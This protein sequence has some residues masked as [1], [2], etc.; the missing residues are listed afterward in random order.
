GG[1]RAAGGVPA[2]GGGGGG[3]R[4]IV[5]AP[6]ARAGRGARATTALWAPLRP[7]TEA[8]MPLS[9]GGQPLDEASLGPYRPVLGRLIPDWRDGTQPDQSSMVVLGEAVLRLLAAT[10]RGS[11]SVLILEDLHDADTET[12]AVVEYLI[13]NLEQLPVMLLATV[14]A[15][16][17]DALGLA[18][19]AARRRTGTVLRLPPLSRTEVIRMITSCLDADPTQVPA[20]L[21]QRLWK[22]SA[23]NPFLV[24]ELL[25]GIIGDGSLVRDGAGGWRMIGDIRLNLPSALVQGVIHRIDRLGSQGQMLMSAAAVLG[26]RF[27]LS[28]LQQMTGIDD[29]SLLSHLHAGVAA[30]LVIPDE[31]APDWYAF[32]HPLTAEAL[33]TQLTPTNRAGLSERAADAV[34]ALHPGLEGEWCPLV[35]SLRSDAGDAARAGRLFTEAGRRALEDGAI[36][37]AVALLDRAERLLATGPDTAARAEALEALLPAL[38]ETGD[39]E[40]AL[41]L[42]DSLRQLVG[43]GLGATRLAALHTRLAQV[44][45]MAG[46][47]A[48]GN[49]QIARARALLGPEPDEVHTAQ[50]DVV[51]AYLTLD[52]PGPDRTQRAE[53]LVSSAIDAAERHQLPLVACQAWELLGVL[54]RERDMGEA[55]ACLQQ[56]LETAERHN[57]PLQRMYA[58][59]RL[60][61][62]HW[63]ASGDTTTLATAREE[64]QRLGAVTVVYTIDGILVLHSVLLGR[65]AEARELS[66]ECLTMAVRLRLAPVARYVLMA[67]AVL[68]AHQGDRT[69]MDDALAEFRRTDGTGSQ[70]EPLVYGLAGAFCALLEE[71]RPRA[72]RELDKVRALEAENPTTFHLDGRRGIGLLLDVLAGTADRGRH[73]EIATSSAGRM[74]WN[75]H[76][77]LLADAVLLGQEGHPEAAA[78]AAHEAQEIAAAHPTALHLGHRLVAE[79]AH[80]AHWGAP[81]SWLRQAEHHFEQTSIPAVAG[82]CRSLLRQI[83]A[84][85]RQHRAGSN[86]IPAQLRT[87]GVTVREYEVF[88]LL[89]DRLSNKAIATRLYIS[90]RTVEKH[91]ASLITKTAQPNRTALCELSASQ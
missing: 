81:E 60:G 84:P 79:A 26:R 56:V 46:R 83:G 65:F 76:F 78:S 7:L 9:R 86:R 45:H 12:L 87:Q 71:D 4:G 73:H 32:R 89:A 77:V 55:A 64:A 48:D 5:R 88:Q 22:D 23:G 34:E 54:A 14:R 68:A 19:S 57:L 28:V 40:R 6:T 29:R 37:S 33:L 25:Q 30:Q 38:A 80:A 59:A 11:G 15:E 69:A 49:D 3:G 36:G 66:D 50:I 18:H 39:I 17:S 62:T 8:L 75:R 63:L 2:L 27:P 1:S 24:E 67:R 20:E 42:A 91:I 10:G 72:L 53:R 13:D 85:V 52:T 16:P 70:E 43:G 47:W 51:A 35:A 74:R 90:P 58:L 44:A 21:L 41:S 61:G 82:A 31:P